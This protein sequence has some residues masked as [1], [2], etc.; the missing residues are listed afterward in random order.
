M[1]TARLGQLGCYAIALLT[2]LSPALAQSVDRAEVEKIV[3][4]YIIQNPEII[5]EA[6]TELERRNQVAEAQARS[7]AILAETDALLRSSD[8]VILGNPV[9]DAT[10]VEFFD[11]NCGYCKRAAPDVKALVAE[12]PN[13]RV[14]LKEFPIL[15]PGSVEAAKVALSVK[16]L[17]GD[18]A[19]R[20]F[21]IRLM[22]MQGQINANRALD[23]S[24]N[25]GLD[26]KK[27]SEEMVTPAVEAIVAANL[28]LAQRLGLT[29][30]PSFVVGDQIIEGAV[31]KE[32]LADAIN[33][34]RQK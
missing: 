34:V 27:L 20:D 25:M 4:E 23:L 9:G 6:L 8:D 5:E 11:F 12:D 29:G 3:R 15:G 30:T 1:T 33:V 19:A 28:A 17:A 7:Q 24:E 13:L 2:T 18:A 22:E 31:G 10:L 14:V 32:P 21:H 26:R 16:R